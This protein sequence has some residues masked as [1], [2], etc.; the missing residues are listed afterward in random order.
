MGYLFF[1]PL[2]PLP[3]DPSA[4]QILSLQF[5]QI[6]WYEW[7]EVLKLS[8][9]IQLSSK[10]QYGLSKEEFFGSCLHRV[11]FSPSY[12]STPASV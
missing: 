8:I 11:H 4:P 5:Q 12:L 2:S 9:K 10:I 7:D 6:G 1:L 3:F